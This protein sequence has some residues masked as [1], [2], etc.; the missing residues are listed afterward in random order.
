M[1]S[2]ISASCD[3][4]N[5]SSHIAGVVFRCAVG[6]QADAE[7]VDAEPRPGGDDVAADR[8]RRQ[9]AAFHQPAPAGVQHQRVPEHDHQRA[10]FLRVPAPEAA[11]RV[12]GP[13]A[14]Q[15]RADEAEEDR[16]AQRAVD[17]AQ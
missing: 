7:L 2:A 1:P 3:A 6:V 14:A 8:E 11:P 5:V 15:H 16:E 13:Q 10:V 12:V 4:A 17:H 9:A